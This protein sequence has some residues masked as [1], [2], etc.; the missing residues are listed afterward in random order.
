MDEHI[1]CEN[2]GREV[3]LSDLPI[4]DRHHRPHVWNCAYCYQHPS[5]IRTHQI[6]LKGMM[7]KK[8]KCPYHKGDKCV[9]FKVNDDH[10][11]CEP[12]DHCKLKYVE[13][14]MI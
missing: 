12:H 14:G 9:M 5:K 4:Q 11:Y 1:H 2:C 13:G 7:V 10:P 6:R 3:L 8:P